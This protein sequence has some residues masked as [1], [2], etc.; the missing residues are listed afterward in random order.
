VILN[1]WVEIFDLYER[2]KWELE[3]KERALRSSLTAIGMANAG[4]ELVYA[5]ETLL[6]MWGYEQEEEIL[7]RPVLD[8]WKDREKAGEVYETLLS[9]GSWSGELEALRKDGSEFKVLIQANLVRDRR[10]RPELLFC[11]VLDVTQQKRM[12]EALRESEERYRR[13]F[14]EAPDVIYTI[15]GEEGI[16]T[17]LNPAFEKITGWSREEWIGKSFA[18]LVHPEDLRLAMETFEWSLRGGGG[19]K[20]DPTS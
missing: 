9:E 14:D 7:G 11:S 6:S 13:L 3:I 1:R 4:G 20:W 5:N 15:S 18:G 10:G 16:I 12:E 8:F 17:S 19:V 2:M